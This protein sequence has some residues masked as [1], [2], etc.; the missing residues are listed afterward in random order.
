VF[1][2]S[3]ARGGEEELTS[4]Q[5]FVAYDLRV[6]SRSPSACRQMARL[7]QGSRSGRVHTS[8]GMETCLIQWRDVDSTS[9]H[10]GDMLRLALRTFKAVRT[11]FSERDKL[12]L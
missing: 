8:G 12:M 2:P 5:T 7:N 9:S 10:P 3:C 4:A 11:I 6:A 1:A